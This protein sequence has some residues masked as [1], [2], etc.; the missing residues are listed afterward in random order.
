M[1][2]SRNLKDNELNIPAED[3]ALHGLAPE[4]VQEK[5]IQQEHCFQNYIR[6]FSDVG[7]VHVLVRSRW[8][9]QNY[10]PA[11]SV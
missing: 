9:L 3:R 4:E 8:S 10:Q 5:A 1:P 6:V 11:H 7:P 2:A